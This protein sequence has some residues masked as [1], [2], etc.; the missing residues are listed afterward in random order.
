[1]RLVEGD[2][3]VSDAWPERRPQARLGR[4][5]HRRAAAAFARPMRYV[6]KGGA[7]GAHDAGAGGR[8]ANGKSRSR[9]ARSRTGVITHKATN[10]ST[11]YGKVA[12]AAGKIEPPQEIKLKDPKDWKVIGKASSGSTPRTRSSARR[13]TASTCGCPACSTPPSRPARSYGGK[14]KSFDAAKVSGEQGRQEGRSGRG[15]CRRGRCRQLVA[16][17]DRARCAADR[18][19]RGRKCQGV[20]R[21]RLPDGSR[22]ASTP[23]R[24]SSATRAAT[25]KPRLAGAAKKVEAVYAYPYQ[26]HVTMEP[27]N[28]TARYT[29]DKCEVWTRP[30]TAKQA[31]ARPHRRPAACRSPNAK[32]TRPSSAAASAGARPR[33]TTSARRY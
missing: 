5:L 21:N 25:S 18:L 12:E 24:R 15:L 3:R 30:R 11:T 20:K 6:R 13:S 14:V 27:Q 31:L 22:K 19:G 17:Q 26:H 32:S 10:R 23:I 28:A 8:R 2:V 33:R 9:S 29:A 7:A 4:L 1:M 16:G